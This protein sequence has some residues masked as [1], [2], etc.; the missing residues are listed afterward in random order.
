MCY[1]KRLYNNSALKCADVLKRRW[2]INQ[3]DCGR[4]SHSDSRNVGQEGGWI[5]AALFIMR[6]NVTHTRFFF[7]NFQESLQY[8]TWRTL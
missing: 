4:I 7:V 2:S 6:L 3:E 5:W 8:K 1:C